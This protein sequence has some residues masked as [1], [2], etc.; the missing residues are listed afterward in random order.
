MTRERWHGTLLV[1]TA[2]A[3]PIGEGLALGLGAALALVAVWRWRELRWSSLATSPAGPVLAGLAVWAA[4]GLV[5]IVIGGEGWQKP[6]ELG[7]WAP[8]LLVPLVVVSAT[9]VPAV[10]LDRAAKAFVMALA[11]ACFFGLVQYL[12]NVRPGEA[13]WRSDA[14]LAAQGRIPGDASHTVAGGFYFHRLRMAHVTALGVGLLVARQLFAVLGRR[15]RFVELGLL[16]VMSV[17]LLLTYTRGAVLAVAVAALVSVTLA[18]RRVR[19]A[20]IAGLVCAALATVAIPSVRERVVS[21]GSQ[22]ASDVRSLIWSQ[23]IDLIA[24][25]PFG[26]GFGNYAAVVGRYFDAVEPGFASRTYPHNIWLAAWAE[27]GPLGM[28]AYVFAY[29]AFLLACLRHLKAVRNSRG[30]AAAGTGVFG[31]IAVLVIGLT[32]DV[33]FHNAV[34]LAFSGLVGLTLAFL[35]RDAAPEA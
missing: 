25:H 24:D 5:A 16:V 28:G 19:L 1:L 34:A 17:T 30:R 35:A 15:R 27:A 10:W 13:L 14:G 9:G 3:I 6:A 22:E 18:S 8:L 26:I 29:T 21:S 33:L 2:A 4:C 11:V 23:A 32:H 12:F 31:V 20:A 7:R